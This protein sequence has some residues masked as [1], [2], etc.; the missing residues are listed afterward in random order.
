[1]RDEEAVAIRFLMN[2]PLVIPPSTPQAKLDEAITITV[3][4]LAARERAVWL[5]AAKM[6]EE[7]KSTGGTTSPGQATI[8]RLAVRCRQQAEAVKP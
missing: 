8:C 2:L 3:A 5:E 7:Y 6:I 4:F 1:M